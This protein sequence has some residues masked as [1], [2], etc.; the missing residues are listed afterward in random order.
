VAASASVAPTLP[1]AAA[2]VTG[3]AGRH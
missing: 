1:A 3:T 2:T